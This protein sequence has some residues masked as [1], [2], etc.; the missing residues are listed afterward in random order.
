MEAAS[1]PKKDETDRLEELKNIISAE[2]AEIDKLIQGSK[3]LKEKVGM[4]IHRI[5]ICKKILSSLITQ[6]AGYSFFGLFQAL[7]LQ[8]KIENAGGEKLKEQKEKV[9]KIQSVS[10]SLLK[11]SYYGKCSA[12]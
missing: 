3:K 6:F 9:S 7:E 4:G 5:K 2:E 11:A 12:Y 8:S 1:K 10:Y